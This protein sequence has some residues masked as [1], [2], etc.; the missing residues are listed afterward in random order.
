MPW[1]IKTER[2]KQQTLKLSHAEREVYLESHKKWV[3]KLKNSGINISSGYLLDSSHLPGGGGL[4]I[5]QSECFQSAKALIETD[6]MITSGLVEW[7]LH[8]W[9]R[10]AGKSPA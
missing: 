7:Q 3:E 6:P 5:F 1:F 10:V 9:V 2:F 4:L 8:E